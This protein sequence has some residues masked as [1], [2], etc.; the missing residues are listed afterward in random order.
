[1]FM[2]ALTLLAAT[3]VAR[4][5]LTLW[6]FEVLTNLPV[7][8]LIATVLVTIAAI[9]LRARIT[10]AVCAMVI[11]VNAIGI[12]AVVR[13]QPN[14]A[15]ILAGSP[16]LTI[17]HLNAQSGS[18][19]VAALRTM[20]RT[21]HPDVFVVLDPS[22]QDARALVH[23]SA[24]YHVVTT[25]SVTSAW[26]RTVVLARVPIS[27]VVHLASPNLP[28]AAVTYVVTLSHIPISVLVLHTESP[29][30]P[31]RASARN[32]ALDAAARWARHRGGRVVVMG[33]FNASP[34]SPVFTK[35]VATSGLRNSL[36]GFG[37]QASWPAALGW[38]GIPIDQALTS[39]TLVTV[40]RAT[41]DGFGS[42]HRSLLLTVAQR[43]AGAPSAR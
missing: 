3:G 18:I 22:Q 8:L 29:T 15:R 27:G 41:T 42:N 14:D 9:I 19:N 17:G 28:P 6:P 33:D 25:A 31:G 21:Q 23:D 10:I 38:A 26:V 40:N 24:G 20:L 32:R 4:L 7:Q 34:W 5:R 35:F 43:T 36:N 12:A 13:R 2:S 39:P 37:Q 16:T 1:M 30:T 11:I